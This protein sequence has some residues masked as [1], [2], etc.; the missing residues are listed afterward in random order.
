VREE[1]EERGE[2]E[3][4]ERSERRERDFALRQADRQRQNDK[5]RHR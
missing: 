3:R 5:E 2:R 4:R 1:R